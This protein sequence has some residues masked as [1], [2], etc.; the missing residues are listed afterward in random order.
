MSIGST[1]SIL[2]HTIV[3]WE[4][5]HAYFG[6]AI[7]LFNANPLTYC[8]ATRIAK[9]L[10]KEE[11]FFQLPGQKLSTGINVQ[12]AFK[13]NSAN[14]AGNVLYGGAI[15]NCKLTGLDSYNSGKVF[16][17]LVQYEGNNTT[18][19]I[20]SDPFHLHPCKKKKKNIQNVVSKTRHYQSTLVKHF[21][22]QW[23]L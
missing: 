7:Y 3:H 11:C 10:F 8:T 2:P 5:N 18:S 23:L 17:M 13:N 6:G 15:D 20:S 21:T 16:D 14:N 19:N 22:F 4:N 12:L 9:Y 1:F